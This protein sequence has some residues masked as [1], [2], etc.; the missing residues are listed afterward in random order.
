[1]T[2]STVSNCFSNLLLGI[3]LIIKSRNSRLCWATRTRITAEF[4]LLKHA[5]DLIAQKHVTAVC[6][7]KHASNEIGKNGLYARRYANICTFR[8]LIVRV[9]TESTVATPSATDFSRVYI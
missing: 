9:G 6:V 4:H 5:I 1:M 3:V 8:K 7:Q 2:H